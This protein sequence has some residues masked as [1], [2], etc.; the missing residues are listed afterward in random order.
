MLEFLWIKLHTCY[1]YLYLF[2]HEEHVPINSKR[3][4]LQKNEKKLNESI[5]FL[6]N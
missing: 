5:E 4:F 2:E 3:Y 6:K 1:Y